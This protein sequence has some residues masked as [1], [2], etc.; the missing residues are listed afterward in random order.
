MHIIA[1][2]CLIAAFFLA[3]KAIE[4]KPEPVLY[5][6]CSNGAWVAFVVG[7]VTWLLL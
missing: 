6:V 1:Q 5:P 2:V 4:Y 7:V 3:L